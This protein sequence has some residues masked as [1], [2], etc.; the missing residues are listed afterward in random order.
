MRL[1]TSK[2]NIKALP[3]GAP[4]ALRFVSKKSS[5]DQQM[6]KSSEKNSLAPKQLYKC[7]W[8]A[9]ENPESDRNEAEN[10]E[11]RAPKETSCLLLCISEQQIQ[12]N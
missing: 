5:A 7:C 11:Q 3:S 4:W 10:P 9:K 8:Q 2:Y 6:A 1:T 12:L